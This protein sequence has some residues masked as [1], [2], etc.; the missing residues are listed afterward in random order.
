[1]AFQEWQ[2][3]DIIVQPSALIEIKKESVLPIIRKAE[4]ISKYKK[5]CQ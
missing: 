4:V 5:Q 3:L 2:V 1:M